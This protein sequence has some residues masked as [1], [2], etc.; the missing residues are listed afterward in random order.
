[1]DQHIGNKGKLGHGITIA[2]GLDA[3][4]Y[5]QSCKPIVILSLS[6]DRI[7]EL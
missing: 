1:M 7:F 2:D 6:A 4:V 3:Q 5:E